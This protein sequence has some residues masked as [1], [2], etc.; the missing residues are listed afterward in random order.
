MPCTQMNVVRQMLCECRDVIRVA[1]VCSLRKPSTQ[2]FHTVM[3]LNA[4]AFNSSRTCLI[5]EY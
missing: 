4:E 5:C 1:D 2:D 3:C